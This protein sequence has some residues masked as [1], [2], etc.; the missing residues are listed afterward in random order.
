MCPIALS[1]L[2]ELET[3]GICKMYNDP[4]TKKEP[5]DLTKAFFI[6]IGYASSIGGV[7]TLIGTASNLTLKGYFD[8]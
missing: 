6:G 7:G 3:Q 4:E 1:L 2:Q 8:R 5:S